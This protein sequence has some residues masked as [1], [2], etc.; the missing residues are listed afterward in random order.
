[1]R[2]L[3]NSSGKIVAIECDE[4]EVRDGSLG[5][6]IA[7]GE[8]AYG[9]EPDARNYTC[10]SCGKPKVFGLEECLMRGWVRIPEDA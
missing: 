9:V 2:A 4:D 1:M 3:L 6:C 10:E 7:C 5:V 8:E